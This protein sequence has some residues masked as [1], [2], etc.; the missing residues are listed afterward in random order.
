MKL[1]ILTPT[2]K[3]VTD[4]EITDLFVPG[5]EGEIEIL[6]QHANFVTELQPGVVRWKT[7]GSWQAAAVSF[8][9]VEIF[10]DTVSILAD[11][12]EMS[13]D[14]DEERAKRASAMAFQKVSEGGMPDS[15]QR[16]YELKLQRSLSRIAA[17][18]AVN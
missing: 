11:V 2:K 3:L 4:E 6:P 13:S 9:W 12:G 1:S 18:S 14:I 10:G 17:K 15:E 7:A 5:L 8:G 16:K